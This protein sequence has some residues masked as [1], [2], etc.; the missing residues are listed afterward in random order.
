MNKPS[1]LI[2]RFALMTQ[3]ADS[4]HMLH[5]LSLDANSMAISHWQEHE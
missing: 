3:D 1:D 2:G 4:E 5:Q